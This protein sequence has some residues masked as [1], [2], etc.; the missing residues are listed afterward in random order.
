MN[1]T[2]SAA[3]GTTLFHL[4]AKYLGDARL[5]SRI[6]YINNLQDPFLSN[7]SVIILPDKIASQPA[8]NVWQ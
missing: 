1:T 5:W 4:A 6:A 3:S 7:A 8:N 2:I